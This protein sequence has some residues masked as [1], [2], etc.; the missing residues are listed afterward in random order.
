[1]HWKNNVVCIVLSLLWIVPLHAQDV[2]S[3]DDAL[4]FTL[5]QNYSIKMARLDEQA[6]KNNASRANSG[7]V[8][9]VNGTGAYNWTL[10]KGTTEAISG[11]T[12]FDAASSYNY[13]AGVSLN[14]TL[15]DGQGRKFDYLQLKETHALSQLQ[16]RQLIENTI[17]ELSTIYYDVLKLQEAD[18]SLQQA[19]E[20]SKERLQRAEYAYEYGQANQLDILNAKV[21]LN[22]DSIN[23]VNNLQVLGNARRT[24]N[25]VMGTE[26]ETLYNLADELVI[27][28][29]I[30][31]NDVVSATLANNVE[32]AALNSDLKI[33]ELSIGSAKSNWLPGLGVNAGYSYRGTDD[34]NGAF[35]TGSSS[36]GPNAGL[37]LNWS[38]FD[39]RN[40]TRVQNAK[41]DLESKRIEEES[42]K[43]TVRL[44]ALNAYAVYTNALFVMQAQQENVNTAQNNFERS[45]EAFK[46][47]SITSVEF[48]QAQVNLLNTK[49][50]YS[51]AKYNAKNAELNVLALMGAL[52]NN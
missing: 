47:A 6:A 50:Q 3:F 22:V 12:D 18:S 2:L 23:L 8:P 24:L 28:Q 13:N 40:K 31:E 27:N 34:P 30:Q 21:D 4:K 44:N 26:I 37:S 1:M 19:L 42:V 35:V 45:Q 9:N 41:I 39:F 52:M 7:Y 17:L 15:F 5:E 48:R 49:L 25:L 32:I 11:D 33:A 10:Y 51:E 20:I 14:Y 36:Y 46:L 38:L 29:N 16:V 43:Q